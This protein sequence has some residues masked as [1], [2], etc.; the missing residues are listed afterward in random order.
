MKPLTCK[1]LL[2][3]ALFAC[4]MMQLRAQNYSVGWFKVAGGGGTSTG[5]VYTVNGTFG[6]QDAGGPINGGGYSVKGGFWSLFADQSSSVTGN[7]P[8]IISQPQSLIVSNG[9]SG[10]FPVTATGTPPLFYQWQKNGINLTDGG[11][12]SGSTTA[13]LYLNTTSSNDLASY[14][15]VIEN[16]YG[17]VTSSV[18]ILTGLLPDIIVQPQ[19][20]VTPGGNPASFS[21]VV[22]GSQAFSIQWERNGNFLTDGG[23]IS[24][25]A[26]TTL[27]L[28][29]TSTNNDTGRYA[30]VLQNVYGSESTSVAELTLVMPEYTPAQG[31][32]YHGVSGLLSWDVY[33]SGPDAI[34]AINQIE[35]IDNSSF[36][37]ADQLISDKTTG[38]VYH[39]HS[40]LS[41]TYQSCGPSGGGGTLCQNNPLYENQSWTVYGSIADA[42]DGNNVMETISTPTW[43]MF[44]KWVTDYT[45]GL[46]YHGNWDGTGNPSWAVYNSVSD[47]IQDINQIGTVTSAADWNM[48]D[49]WFSDPNTGLA[50]HG[51]TDANNDNPSWAVYNSVS[52]AIQDINQIGVVISADDWSGYDLWV[53]L[54]TPAVSIPFSFPPKFTAIAKTGGAFQF[55]WNTVNTYP[56]IGYQVQYTANLFPANWLNL[57]SVLTGPAATLSLTNS[58][59]ANPQGFYRLVLSPASANIFQDAFDPTI[60]TGIGI[61]YDGGDVADAAVSVVSNIGVAGLPALQIQCSVTN[62][63]NGYAY[64][65]GQ[66]QDLNVSGNTDANLSDYYLSFDA[67]VTGD[68]AH[69]SGGGFALQLQEGAG[70]NFST[71]FP[72]GQLQTYQAYQGGSDLLVPQSGVWKHFTIN[73]GGSQF[74][75]P[76]GTN[77]TFN[78]MGGS[79]QLIFQL[80]SLDWGAEPQTNSTLI[81]DNIVL[82]DLTPP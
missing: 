27:Y 19:S 5:G 16:A 61:S 26:T 25:A 64:L 56:P 77:I 15:V 43:S 31:A 72:Q 52:D 45:T 75:S 48:F 46:V 8:I 68:A 34:E 73:L 66:W 10:S 41:G 14:S 9:L 38:L 21:V 71:T 42:F 58:I 63:L 37:Y 2:A 50:Y 67:Y 4:T 80:N 33:N 23:N 18:V 57:G 24:G 79:W 35:A 47:A 51:N 81:I 74:Q 49:R 82:T 65:A 22:A 76:N 55:S 59:G 12:I 20:Q 44:D 70:A 62:G 3:L 78:P 28:S 13:N 1:I 11:N 39:G 40:T 60:G 29:T 53:G 7:T 6:Q 69:R 54:Y 36:Q 32:V 30:A 17:S